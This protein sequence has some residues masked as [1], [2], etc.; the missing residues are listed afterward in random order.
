MARVVQAFVPVA[1]P[2]VTHN[3]LV[4]YVRSNGRPGIRKSDRLRE[5]EDA[6]LPRLASLAPSSGPLSGPLRVTVRWCFPAAAT[7]HAQGEPHVC[8]PDMSNMLK[9]LEDV[10]QRAGVIADDSM[11]VEERLSKAW[12]DPAGIF[13]RAEEL[14]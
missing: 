12:M 3:D 11:V 4:A 14:S 6:L 8:R 13:V 10:M 9:T 7:R 1:P 5:A 2:T